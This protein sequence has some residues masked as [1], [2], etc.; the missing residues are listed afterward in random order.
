MIKTNMNTDDKEV[1]K[2]NL[3]AAHWWDPEGPCKPL[4]QLNPVR[5]AYIQSCCDLQQK[6][7]LDV[8]CGGGILTETMSRFSPHVVGIDLA[9]DTL[10]AAKVHAQDLPTPPRYEE[11]SGEAYAALHPEA[12]SIVTCMELLEHVPDPVSLLRALTTLLKPGGDLFL[13]TV[14]RTPKAFV[15]AIIGAEYL[16]R[17]LPI[18][19]HDYQR[20]IKP[21]EIATWI[22][23]LGLKIVS[24]RG[25]QYHLLSRT[26]SLSSKVDVNYVVHL[27]KMDEE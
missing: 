14:N 13:S 15:Q 1:Q 7:I 23:G 27:K 2:F 4:H 10:Q 9:R 12:F 26:F 24:L 5:M 21:S 6:T 18:G 3:M 20:F 11:A 16:L 8:G 19:T 17:I 25:I 22:K